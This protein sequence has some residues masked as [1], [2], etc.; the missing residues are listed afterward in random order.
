MVGASMRSSDI[1]ARFGG[2]EF[3]MVL[4]DCSLDDALRVAERLQ[5]AVAEWAGQAGITLS[6]SIGLGQ[7]PQHGHDLDSVLEQVDSAMYRGKLSFGKGGIQLV[8]VVCTNP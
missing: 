1:A 7:A 8:E 4:P 6:I 3:V 2:D 5:Q